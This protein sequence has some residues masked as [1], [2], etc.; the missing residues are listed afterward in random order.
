MVRLYKEPAKNMS[1]VDEQEA[2]TGKAR[3][4]AME[5]TAS[6]YRCHNCG[7]PLFYYEEKMENKMTMNVENRVAG[8]EDENPDDWCSPWK[9][10][11]C[12]AEIPS[13]FESLLTYASSWWS[14]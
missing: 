11:E 6:N 3:I 7:S 4:E 5:E 10:Q 9:C 13:E 12:E 8:W 14:S 1:G 2:L